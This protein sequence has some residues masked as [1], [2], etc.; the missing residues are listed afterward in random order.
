MASERKKNIKE[1]KHDRQTLPVS[2][3][4]AIYSLVVA[5]SP[6]NYYWIFLQV[7]PFSV[8]L[9]HFIEVLRW[10]AHLEKDLRFTYLSIQG[11][12][13]RKNCWSPS[14]RLLRHT[15]HEIHSDHF[16]LQ[17]GR[18]DSPSNE[19]RGSKVFVVRDIGA[20]FCCHG[21]WK[22]GSVVYWTHN[23]YAYRHRNYRKCH[24]HYC[25]VRLPRYWEQ[26][27]AALKVGF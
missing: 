21:C 23:G 20:R 10:S 17:Q 19:C 13:Q 14:K 22:G 18:R 11:L 24:N 8:Q 7:F 15:C 9:R 6:T 27:A 3:M 5:R 2:F 12:S 26:A 25:C 16:S 4:F 1:G